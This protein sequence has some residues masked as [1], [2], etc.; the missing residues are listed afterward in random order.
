MANYH[1]LQINYKSGDVYEKSKDPKEGFE[2]NKYTDPESGEQRT[3]YH[4]KYKENLSGKLTDVRYTPS[5]YGDKI[6]FTLKDG[7]ENYIFQMNFENKFGNIDDFALD[8]ICKCPNLEKGGYYTVSPFVYTPEP[9]EGKKERTFRGITF[10]DEE[11]DKIEKNITLSY[12]KAVRD[13][14][15]KIKKKKDEIV[16]E[17]I[18][19]D[20]PAE[21]WKQNKRGKWTVD[22]EDKMDW[23]YEWFTTYAQTNFQSG[24]Q[25]KEEE[26][27]EKE[28]PVTTD[29]NTKGAEDTEDDLPF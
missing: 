8:F 5:P 9:E 15:G 19:G 7:D 29:S 10:W 21:I 13:K 28:E 24:S 18:E 11:E 1:Y 26:V 23:L 12:Y 20:V 4:K 17:L 3:N 16:T 27:K 22:C 14:N 25:E 2:E 6:S